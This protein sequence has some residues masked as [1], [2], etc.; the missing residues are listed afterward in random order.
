M[1]ALAGDLPGFEEAS[2]ALFAGD[3]ERFHQLLA[4]WPVDVREHVAHLAEP[5][6]SGATA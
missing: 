5:E 2:C 4:A 6:G 3:R 1:S